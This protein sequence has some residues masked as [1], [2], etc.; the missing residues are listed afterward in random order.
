MDMNLSKLWEIVKNKGAWCAAVQGFAKNRTWLSNRTELKD[1]FAWLPHCLSLSTLPFD[2]SFS[3]LFSLWSVKEPG[4]QTPIRWLFWGASLPSCWSAS[5]P[6]KVSSCLNTSSLGFTGLSCSEQSE[7]GL[8]TIRY[9]WFLLTV[10]LEWRYNLSH[11]KDSPRA[12]DI[13]PVFQQIN[14]LTLFCS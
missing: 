7:L 2:S 4:I 12:G 8:N 10:L 14:N 1:P 9:Y 11:I 6:T 13:Y 3:L 5:S